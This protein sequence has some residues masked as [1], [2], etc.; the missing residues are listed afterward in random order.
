MN[1]HVPPILLSVKRREDGTVYKECVDGKQRVTA[2]CQFMDG[3]ISY[4]DFDTGDTLW[5]TDN[6]EVQKNKSLLRKEHRDIFSRRNII[7]IEYEDLVPQQEREIFL[8]VQEGVSLT[9]AEKMATICTPRADFARSLVNQYFTEDKLGHSDIPLNLNRGWDLACFGAMVSLISQW[10]NADA[11]PKWLVTNDINKWLVERKGGPKRLLKPRSSGKGVMG[12]GKGKKD[13]KSDEDTDEDD[14]VDE[15][16][17]EDEH[18]AGVPVDESLIKVVKRA[19]DKLVEISDNERSF[20]AL[21]SLSYAKTIAPVEVIG[22]V[23]LVHAICCSISSQERLNLLLPRLVLL[24]RL[25]S[26]KDYKRDLRLRVDVGKYMLSSS[27][28]WSRIP[29][30]CLRTTRMRSCLSLRVSL[31]RPVRVGTATQ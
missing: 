24:F 23:L 21:R 29:K 30:G 8:R 18:E 26:H 16:I 2:I 3:R 10:T 1:S 5:Y 6:K 31:I 4:K 27:R 13:E 9:N 19:L 15:L 17:S 28:T 11:T 25:K 22:I 12:K 14:N 20:H 7:C